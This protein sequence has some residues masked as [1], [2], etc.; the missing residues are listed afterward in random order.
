MHR[1]GSNHSCVFRCQFRTQSSRISRT[2]AASSF[3]RYILSTGNTRL[4]GDTVSD[5]EILHLV[6]DLD[7][8][9]GAL[10]AQDDGALEDEVANAAPLPV[11][12]IRATDAGLLDVDA[13]IVLVAELWDLAAL[14]RDVLDGLED[15][16][17]V[18]KRCIS[19]LA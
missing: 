9:P 2:P 10:V 19:F 13:H 16:R 11:V 3:R 7:N 6:A 12:D 5:L 18:L 17:R 14:K 15:K 4:D 1:R 8:S